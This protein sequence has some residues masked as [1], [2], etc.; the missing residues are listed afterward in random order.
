LGLGALSAVFVWRLAARA[1]WRAVVAVAILRLLWTVGEQVAAVDD[2]AV[3]ELVE[4]L[5]LDSVATFNLA[6]STDVCGV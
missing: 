5:G 4:L 3:G 6:G 1:Q 2:L